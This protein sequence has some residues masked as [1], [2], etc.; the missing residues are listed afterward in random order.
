MAFCSSCG[1]SLNLG[2]AFCSA[3]GAKVKGAPS[4]AGKLIVYGITQ[5]FLVG[6]TL[7][8]YADG[9]LIGEVRK[10]EKVEF[11][12]TKNCIITAKCGVN[13]IKEKTSVKGGITTV[14]RYEYERISSS[15]I[16]NV[17]EY[18]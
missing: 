8:I 1:K 2:V 10:N 18:V 7:K 11:P 3:C 15:F 6:G 5:K 12:I 4:G 16:A 14:I 13:P 17:S 9:V